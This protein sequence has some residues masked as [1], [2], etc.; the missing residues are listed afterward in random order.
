LFQSVWKWF[1]LRLMAQTLSAVQQISRE[2]KSVFALKVL[3]AKRIKVDAKLKC[4]IVMYAL[5]VN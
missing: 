4:K 2:S 5:K 1:V 3:I